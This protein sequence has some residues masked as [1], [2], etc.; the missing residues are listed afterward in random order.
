MLSWKK[1]PLRDPP[2]GYPLP[3]YRKCFK[4]R[5][6]FNPLPIQTMIRGEDV[7]EDLEDLEEECGIYFLEGRALPSIGFPCWIRSCVH[8]PIRQQQ[9]QTGPYLNYD[10]LM[11]L[12]QFIR[13][14]ATLKA[15]DTAIGLAPCTSLFCNGVVTERWYETSLT[16]LSLA[17]MEFNKQDNQ[18]PCSIR[19]QDTYYCLSRTLYGINMVM[20]KHH[21]MTRRFRPSHHYRNPRN[22]ESDYLPV[23]SIQ[24]V[25][26]AYFSRTWSITQLTN[27]EDR[28]HFLTLVKGYRIIEKWFLRKERD[29]RHYSGWV[30]TAVL[31][32]QEPGQCWLYPDG[33]A[34]TQAHCHSR[35][36]DTEPCLE[37]SQ[38]LY[39]FREWQRHTIPHLLFGVH[40]L[41]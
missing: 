10:T 15:L 36:W 11:H 3:Q 33:M 34:R 2:Q 37:W 17:D 26:P 7:E 18:P 23:N 20:L 35:C 16:A 28:H 12:R 25:N 21:P 31:Q 9:I 5:H 29:R 1:E 19:H 27:K 30:A 22:G 4:T 13:E 6:L 24:I 41:Y 39:D 14:G 32:G 40:D 38:Y 8:D